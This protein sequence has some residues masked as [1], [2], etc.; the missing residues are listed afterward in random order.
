MKT[1]LTS[2]YFS[3]EEMEMLL[4]VGTGGQSDSACLDNII[5]LLT[6]SGRIFAAC[7]DDAHPRSLGWQ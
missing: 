4:P 6:L 5:E 7:H 1:A 3:K 2:P